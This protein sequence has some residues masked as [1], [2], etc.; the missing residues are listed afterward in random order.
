MGEVYD[1][2][3]ARAAATLAVREAGGGRRT[4]LALAGGPGSGKST[5]AA[6]VADRLNKSLGPGT[7]A[8]LPMD[9]YHLTRATLDA[10][11]DPA[12]AHARR[13]A[14]WTFDAA[15]FVAAI[16]AVRPDGEGGRGGKGC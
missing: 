10:F 4:L 9:G 15:G 13:G 8:V 11:P 7:A 3:A 16:R 1:A 2:L 5:A 12:A 6:A 14:P